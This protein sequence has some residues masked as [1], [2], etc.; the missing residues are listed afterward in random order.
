MNRRGGFIERA[1]NKPVEKKN[2]QNPAKIRTPDLQ[3]ISQMLLPSSHL[4]PGRGV[5]DKLHK[6]QCI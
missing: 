2:K 3:N 5:E 1:K 4:I 6:E